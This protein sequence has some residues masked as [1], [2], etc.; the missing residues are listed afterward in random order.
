MCC[1]DAGEAIRGGGTRIPPERRERYA[2]FYDGFAWLTMPVGDMQRLLALTA[3]LAKGN[4]WAPNIRLRSSGLTEFASLHFPARQIR[5]VI[6]R[7]GSAQS[8]RGQRGEQPTRYR[9]GP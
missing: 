1:Q 4:G 8:E 2:A 7:L 5:E 9:I 3:D 6:R